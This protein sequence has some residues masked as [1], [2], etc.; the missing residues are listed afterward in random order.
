MNWLAEMFSERVKLAILQVDMTGISFSQHG[1]E[2]VIYQD[3]PAERLTV[4]S[5]DAGSAD[6][7]A[8]FARCGPERHGRGWYAA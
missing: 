3:L 4:V 1:Y 2:V 7:L 8:F 6:A 5:R